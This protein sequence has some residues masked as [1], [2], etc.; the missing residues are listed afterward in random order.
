VNRNIN[1]KALKKSFWGAISR[2]IGIVMGVAGAGLLYKT[3]GAMTSLAVSVSIFLLAAGF[4]AVWFA[5]Y[6]REID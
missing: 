5:E 3:L 1:K 6:E 2:L 4:F